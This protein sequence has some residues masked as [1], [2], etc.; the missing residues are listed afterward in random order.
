[1][2]SKR[3]GEITPCEKCLP[4]VLD[5]HRKTVDIFMLAISKIRYSSMGEPIGLD[6]NAVI[7]LVKLSDDPTPIE[8]IEK[9]M[10]LS[11]EIIKSGN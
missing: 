9:V 8:T 11:N 2:F 7:E 10:F 5:E 1:L 4:F 6:L 3:K